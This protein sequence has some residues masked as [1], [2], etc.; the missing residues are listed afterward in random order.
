M[1]TKH[2][3]KINSILPIF[4][5]KQINAYVSRILSRLRAMR[6]EKVFPYIASFYQTLVVYDVKRFKKVVESKNFT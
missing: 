1:N 6:K 3:D 5:E 2:A 4:T